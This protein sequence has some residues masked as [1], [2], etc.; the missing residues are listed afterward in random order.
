MRKNISIK[1]VSG[2]DISNTLKS[3]IG[4]NLGVLITE[5]EPNKVKVSFRTRD[6]KIY[7]VSELAVA[8]GGGGHKDAA[9]AV[10]FMPFVEAKE[11]VVKKIKELYNL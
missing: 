9:G 2:N 10:L 6:S 11:L 3:V 1:A 4:W 5:A 8:L 7:N